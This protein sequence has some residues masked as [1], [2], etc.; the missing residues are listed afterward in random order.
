MEPI[1]LQMASVWRALL[2]CFAL[3]GQSVRGFAG[4]ADADRQRFRIEDGIAIAEFA[5]VV[6]FH[7]KPREPL[8]HEFAGQPGVPA[9][10][11]RDDADLLKFAEL[12]VR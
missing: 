12:L 11:A 5:A 2:F 8:D 10:A 1:T 7:G 3:R 6:H 9:G 4:L